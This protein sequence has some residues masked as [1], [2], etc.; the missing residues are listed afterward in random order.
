MTEPESLSLGPY[1]VTE[2]TAHLSLS[3]MHLN[4]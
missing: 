3:R 4:E 1:S 2:H